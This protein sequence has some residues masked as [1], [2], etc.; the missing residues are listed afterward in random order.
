MPRIRP[1]TPPAP[2]TYGRVFRR[3]DRAAWMPLR[4]VGYDVSLAAAPVDMFG[5]VA[6]TLFF[7]PGKNA[8]ADRALR[9]GWKDE[10][11]R[12]RAFVA[13]EVD[14]VLRSPSPVV[15]AASEVEA[16][17]VLPAIPMPTPDAVDGIRP[18]RKRSASAV[19]AAA[20]SSKAG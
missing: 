1:I 8:A 18:I 14:P 20:S 5:V 4:F 10:T 19:A 2:E 7:P 16:T 15:P 6:C 12:W 17:I 13:G 11:A 3:Y 9:Y